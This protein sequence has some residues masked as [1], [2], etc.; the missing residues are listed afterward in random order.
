MD[1]I[2]DC[3][4]QIY[5]LRIQKGYSQEQLAELVGVSRQTIHRWENN[6]IHPSR[7]YK[8][9]LSNVIGLPIST[10]MISLQEMHKLEKAEV[11]LTVLSK[12]KNY[13]ICCIV[14]YILLA[15]LSL[16]I[17]LTIWMGINIGSSQQGDVSATNYYFDKDL[18]T[19]MIIILIILAIIEIILFIIIMKYKKQINLKKEVYNET[20]N[21]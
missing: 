19:L 11:A 10:S 17:I 16:S 18:L 1:E 4:K 9:I 21:D 6:Y 13:L 8:R 5:E 20:I 14:A 3:G 2:D 15:F 7:K 12:N